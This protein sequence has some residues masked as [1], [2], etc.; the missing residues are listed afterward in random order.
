ML[1]S[2]DKITSFA[3][4]WVKLSVMSVLGFLW[5]LQ[6]TVTEKPIGRKGFTQLMPLQHYPSLKSGQEL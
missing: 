3:I 4:I 6:N 1:S 5:L 2:L